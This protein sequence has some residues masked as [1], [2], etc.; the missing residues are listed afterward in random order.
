MSSTL[1]FFRRALAG[2]GRALVAGIV[3]VAALAGP[4]AGAGAAGETLTLTNMPGPAPGSTVAAKAEGTASGDSVLLVYLERDGAGCTATAADHRLKDGVSQVGADPANPDPSATLTA[5]PYDVLIRWAPYPAGTYRL[6]GYLYGSA[7]LINESPLAVATTVLTM[8]DD[9]DA[10]GVPDGSDA[11][12]DVAGTGPDGCPPVPVAPVTRTPPA[13][14]PSPKVPSAPAPAVSDPTGV[15]KLKSSKGRTTACGAGCLART[16]AVGPFSFALKVKVSGGNTTATGSVTLARKSAQA[17]TSG[18]VCLGRFAGTSKQKCRKVTWKVGKKITLTGSIT[19]P[20]TIRTSGRPGFGLS[21][22]VGVLPV[23]GGDSIYLK[24]AGKR[25]V[26]DTNEAA[27][28][29]SAS[30]HM[31]C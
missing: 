24:K 12:P 22:Q 18:K 19:T 21:A 5:G 2:R 30:A 26:P 23:G 20:S 13:A 16:R 28:I 6:C 25:V 27:C 3:A 11:C 7:Q 1:R 29:S 10:D 14:L 15:K 8:I 31:A 4:V 9:N 17:G